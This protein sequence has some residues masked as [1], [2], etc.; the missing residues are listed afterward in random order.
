M[1]VPPPLVPVVSSVRLMLLGRVT[2][3]PPNV[4]STWMESVA[5]TVT[6][7]VADSKSVS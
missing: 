4:P 3:F 6:L 2:A 1:L 7:A 5:L